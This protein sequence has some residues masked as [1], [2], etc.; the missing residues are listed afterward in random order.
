MSSFQRFADERG[1]TLVIVATWLPVLVLFITFV[2]DVGNWFEHKRHLQ[3]QAD[4]GA[5][6]AGGMFNACMGDLLGGG[7]AGSAAIEATAR[8]YAG[9]A[10]T[11]GAYNAQIGGSNRGTVTIRINHKTYA[12]GGPGPDGPEAAGPRP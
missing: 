8:Q 6:A 10:G 2:L 11:S 7:T 12:A 3:T 9:D 5:L 4:A 1:A